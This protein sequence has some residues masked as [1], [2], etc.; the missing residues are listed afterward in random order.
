MLIPTANTLIKVKVDAHSQE[1][2][3]LIKFIYFKISN[4]VFVKKCLITFLKIL[5]NFNIWCLICFKYS[6]E[7]KSVLLPLKNINY[8]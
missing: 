6:L 5:I 1:F 7:L 2:F 4:I 8:F 3:Y